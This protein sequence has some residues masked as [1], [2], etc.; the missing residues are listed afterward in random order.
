M[1]RLLI[2][3]TPA[4]NEPLT[5]WLGKL[6]DREGQ[7]RIR[8]R[9]RRLEAGQMGDCKAL[10]GG[11]YELRFFFG[12]GYRVYFGKDGERMI[13]LLLG[14]DKSGQARDISKAKDYWKE[15]LERK[16]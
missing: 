14:G 13:L 9:L 1:F 16:P 10:G 5:Q 2:Y 4:G 3:K 7:V 15:Y 8:Q 12:A 6:R 11:L